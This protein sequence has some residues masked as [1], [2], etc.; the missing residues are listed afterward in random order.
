MRVALCI[1]VSGRCVVVGMIGVVCCL[2]MAA[3]RA[4][5]PVLYFAEIGIMGQFRA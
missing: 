2:T 3:L 4:F 1:I 5:I